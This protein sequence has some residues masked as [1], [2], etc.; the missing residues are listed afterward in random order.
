MQLPDGPMHTARLRGVRITVGEVLFN[1]RTNR[2]HHRKAGAISASV[3]T[4][5]IPEP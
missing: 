1:F 2:S 3:Q 5:P 4:D